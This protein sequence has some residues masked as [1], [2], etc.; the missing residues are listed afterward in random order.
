ML[1]VWISLLQLGKAFLSLT[2]HLDV[3]ALWHTCMLWEE[4]PHV[5]L[6][7]STA[8]CWVSRRSCGTQCPRVAELALQ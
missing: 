7:I 2:L 4:T 5:F 1:P 6:L 3:G 8:A